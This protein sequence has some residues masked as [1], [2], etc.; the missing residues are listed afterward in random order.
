MSAPPP[1]ANYSLSRS[2]REAINHEPGADSDLQGQPAP[3]LVTQ[4]DGTSNSSCYVPPYDSSD[5]GSQTFAPFNQFKANIYRYRQQ[6]SVNLGSWFVHEQWMTPSLFS[7]AAGDQASEIDIASGWGS[8]EGARAVLERHWDTFVNDTDFQYL[9]D[10]GIN[11]VRLPIGYWTLGPDFC[12]GT[13]YENVS[14]VYQNSWS[15]VVRAI[16]TAAQYGIGVLIDLHGAPGSQNG[17]PHSGISD[18]QANLWGNDVYK[19]KTLDVLTF[20]T[21]QLVKV[22]NVAGI[23]ILNEPNNVGELADFYSTA[24]TTMRQV[25]PAAASLPLYI[26]DGFDLNRFSAFVANRTDFVVQDHHSYFVFTPP[27]EAEPASQHT[28]DIYGGISRSLAGASARQQRNLVVDEFSCALTDESLADES[29]PIE[30]RKD[31]CQAQLDVYRSTTAGWAFWAYN[32]ED[33]FSDPGWCFRAAVGQSLPS[34]F[35]TYGQPRPL[36]DFSNISVL[37]DPATTPGSALYDIAAAL[38]FA[39]NATSAT[40]SASEPSTTA[41]P[42]RAIAKGYSDGFLTAKIFA[43]F[44]MSKLGF[45]GQYIRDSIALLG[46]IVIKPG[47]EHYYEHWFM[48]GLTDGEALISSYVNTTQPMY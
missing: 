31:F 48:A 39:S 43:L 7:C 19:N 13:P 14:T 42:P 25:D 12:Q 29:D 24:I 26:H 2:L 32:K 1:I 11:T 33:C 15:R 5:V 46:P 45:T 38:D 23:Q 27:D 47:T 40:P 9:A 18:G 17:Q 8:P 22:T 10:I 16:N 30:A 6:Q 3:P 44:G 41:P 4:L 37:Y 20:L 36:A 28:S 35:F 34:S 21:Q